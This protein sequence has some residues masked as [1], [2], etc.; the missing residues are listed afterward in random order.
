MR[1]FQ[2]LDLHA[3]VVAAYYLREVGSSDGLFRKEEDGYRCF[4]GRSLPPTKIVKVTNQKCLL[5]P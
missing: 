2:V 4:I 3:K 1:F 5:Y